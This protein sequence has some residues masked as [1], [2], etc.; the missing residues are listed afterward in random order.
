MPHCVHRVVLCMLCSSSACESLVKELAV[1]LL[2]VQQSQLR[3][4]AVLHCIVGLCED[5]SQL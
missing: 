3:G 5:L 4:S 2:C 1:R